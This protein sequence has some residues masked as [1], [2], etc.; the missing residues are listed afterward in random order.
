MAIAKLVPINPISM[1]HD[2]CNDLV[3]WLYKP[4]YNGGAHCRD[5]VDLTRKHAVR[6]K[7]V[8]IYFAT[9]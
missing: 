7:F 1:V 6:L 8:D 3:N 5:V 2:I 4:T 9:L